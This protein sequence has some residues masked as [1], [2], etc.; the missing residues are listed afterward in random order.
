MPLSR[1]QNRFSAPIIDW[2]VASTWFG[3]MPTGQPLGG[4]AL[5][6]ASFSDQ[7]ELFKSAMMAHASLGPP[8]QRI[9]GRPCCRANGGSR[10]DGGAPP[11]GLRARLLAAVI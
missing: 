8:P 3:G 4:A 10:M 7:L 2:A 1:P 6:D 5:F 9:G 11:S